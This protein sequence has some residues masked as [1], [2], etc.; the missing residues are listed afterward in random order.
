MAENRVQRRLAAILAADVV[1]FCMVAPLTD[2]LACGKARYVIYEPAR[3]FRSLILIYLGQER[4]NVPSDFIAF[5]DRR[6]TLVRG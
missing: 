5:L 4:A 1:D 6:W 3:T 2:R